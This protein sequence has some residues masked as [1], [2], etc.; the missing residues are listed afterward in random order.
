MLCIVRGFDT[1]TCWQVAVLLL[2][3]LEAESHDTSCSAGGGVALALAIIL[4][5]NKAKTISTACYGSSCAGTGHSSG[6]TIWLL[7][8]YG[9]SNIVSQKREAA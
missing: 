5:G 9:L 6:W 2:R 1:C 8:Y 7:D 3:R 4:G